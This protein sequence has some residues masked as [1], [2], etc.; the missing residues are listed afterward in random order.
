MGED[1]YRG[2]ER[3]LVTPPALPRRILVPPGVAGLP[4]AHDLGAAPRLA[5][6]HV[7]AGAAGHPG[8]PNVP[9]P[10]IS[11]PIPGSWRRRT[12]SSMPP[13]PPGSPTISCPHRVTNIH[14][15]SRSPAWPNGAS[16]LRPS[17]VPNPSSETEKNWTRA[18]DVAGVPFCLVELGSKRS[19]VVLDA[20]S[21]P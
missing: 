18:S 20:C 2:V 17:P 9:A 11:A 14:S 13:P 1:E 10:M 8:C 16:R 12:A 3:G 19:V 21:I 7:A 15:C 4:G 6:T 5:E